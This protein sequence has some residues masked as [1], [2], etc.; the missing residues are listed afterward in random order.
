MVR[1]S[2]CLKWVVFKFRLEI[3]LGGCKGGQLL[4]HQGSAPL[5]LSC[6]VPA[7]RRARSLLESHRCPRV[8]RR[9]A[10][11]IP[12]TFTPFSRE[13]FPLRRPSR[14]ICHHFP[15]QLRDRGE[16]SKP[17][18]G[19]APFPAGAP[20]PAPARPAPAPGPLRAASPSLYYVIQPR[21]AKPG[22]PA[23]RAFPSALAFHPPRAREGEDVTSSA[24]HLS[25]GVPPGSHPGPCLHAGGARPPRALGFEGGGAAVVSKGRQ[26]RK[27]TWLDVRFL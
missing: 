16:D 4:S 12:L 23:P 27:W 13:R 8:R 21:H 3:I 24:W 11:P 5:G 7:G 18:C 22:L 2:G 19:G 25:P 17:L 9:T 26:E 1:N 6:R 20:P 10:P 14:L 15:G